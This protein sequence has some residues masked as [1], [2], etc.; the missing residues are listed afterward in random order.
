MALVSPDT[1]SSPGPPFSQSLPCTPRMVSLHDHRRPVVA[2][3][4]DELV[5]AGEAVDAVVTRV[6]VD[7]VGRVSPAQVLVARTTL[8]GRGERGPWD[9]GE[10]RGGADE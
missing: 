9:Q 2:R 4:A 10:R 8:D 7:V 3:A 5:V 1:R 6:A